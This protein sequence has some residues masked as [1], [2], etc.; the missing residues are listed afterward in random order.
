VNGRLYFT[1]IDGIYGR[2]LYTIPAA[3]AVAGLTVNGGASQRSRITN[4]TVTF[5]TSTDVTIFQNPGAVTL[6]RTGGGSVT[7]GSGL[8]VT[9]G[10]GTANSITLTFQNASLSGVENGSLADGRWQ[11]AIPSLNYSST[12]NDPNL[13]RLFGDADANGTINAADFA[14]FGNVFGGASVAFDFDNN[15]TINAIDFAEFGNRFGVTM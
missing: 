13:R 8:I 10:A 15:G 6:T 1:A 9:P 5:T 11:L 7:V 4:I 12:L 14:D 3:T 2:E